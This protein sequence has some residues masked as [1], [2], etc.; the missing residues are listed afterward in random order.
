MEIWGICPELVMFSNFFW[1]FLVHPVTS[2]RAFKTFIHHFNVHSNISPQKYPD[3]KSFL[4]IRLHKKY[5]VVIQIATYLT[6]FQWKLHILNYYIWV[7]SF[8]YHTLIYKLY[9]YDS[10]WIWC[11]QLNFFF[12]QESIENICGNTCTV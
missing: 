9:S 1:E 12:L 4:P 10:L 11:K 3:T 5:R 8:G 2:S 7:L 6:T